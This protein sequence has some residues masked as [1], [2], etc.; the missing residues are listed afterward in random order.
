M[1]YFLA[2]RILFGKRRLEHVHLEYMRGQTGAPSDLFISDFKLCHW[3][4][5]NQLQPA[6]AGQT[7]AGAV[8]PELGDAPG[9]WWGFWSPRLGWFHLSCVEHTAAESSPRFSLWF[10]KAEPGGQAAGAAVAPCSHLGCSFPERGWKSRGA[11]A[12]PW[13]LPTCAAQGKGAQVVWGS[14]CERE[15]LA[16]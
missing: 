6:A 9:A 5:K 8:E 3:R 15:P 12:R 10:G 1:L 2:P 7:E 13:C 16:E 14:R 4:K 11:R